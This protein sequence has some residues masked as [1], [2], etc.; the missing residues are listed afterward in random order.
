MLTN[1]KNRL[2][3]AENIGT[4][5]GVTDDDIIDVERNLKQEA[6]FH[7][8]MVSWNV[9]LTDYKTQTQKG[10]RIDEIGCQLYLFKSHVHG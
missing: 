10:G 1:T 4:L 8:A 2:W 9:R 3:E 7:K 5:E 6:R